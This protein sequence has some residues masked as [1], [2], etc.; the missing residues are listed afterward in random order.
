MAAVEDIRIPLD[1]WEHRKTRKLIRRLGLEGVVALQ[2]LW[3]YAARRRPD[4]FLANMTIEDIAL[5][6]KWDGDPDAF[7]TALLSKPDEGGFIDLVE[8]VY[9]LHEWHQHQPWAAGAE[10]RSA[11]AKKGGIAKHN[12]ALERKS[13]SAPSSAGSRT[14]SSAGSKAGSSAPIL[15]FPNP[16]YPNPDLSPRAH[17]RAE[18]DALEPPGR[19]P[20]LEG[21]SEF[22]VYAL[23]LMG[24][25]FMSAMHQQQ[26]RDG[27][28][29][30]ELTGYAAKELLERKA[31]ERQAA[32]KPPWRISHPNF[33][34]TVLDEAC[35]QG[36]A[37]RAIAEKKAAEPDPCAGMY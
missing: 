32:G 3:I 35:R 31:K 21:W 11:I 30:L 22:H 12:K 24:K 37:A 25:P 18:D 6:A 28:L 26:L 2:R 9:Y 5:E 33:F 36:V 29:T 15:S 8:G 17:E 34:V 1:F 20:V 4:G 19:P 10:E 16:S 13:G 7:M 23:S 27:L 14:G